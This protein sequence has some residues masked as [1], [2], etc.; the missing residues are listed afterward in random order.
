MGCRFS[1]FLCRKRQPWDQP[2]LFGLLWSILSVRHVLPGVPVLA[3]K[4]FFNSNQHVIA[5]CSQTTL[6]SLLSL[7]HCKTAYWAANVDAH[8][9]P[10][11]LARRPSACSPMHW[12]DHLMVTLAYWCRFF[13]SVICGLKLVITGSKRTACDYSS[14]YLV[15]EC[16]EKTLLKKCSILLHIGDP[17]FKLLILRCPP[18]EMFL[19]LETSLKG[20]DHFPA[21]AAWL[22]WTKR[23]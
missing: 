21:G 18:A 16:L 1:W 23:N 11:L 6:L 5:L 15:R 12:L 19:R 3:E 8:V 14:K 20:V 2:F 10:T 17:M 22:W 9:L 7:C 4:S 13:S